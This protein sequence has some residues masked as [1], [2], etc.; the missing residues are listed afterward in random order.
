MLLAG[1][2]STFLASEQ[3]QTDNLDHTDTGIGCLGMN[4]EKKNIGHFFLVNLLLTSFDYKA[5]VQSNN[6]A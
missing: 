4:T 2:E 1:F 3:L 6:N 5:E